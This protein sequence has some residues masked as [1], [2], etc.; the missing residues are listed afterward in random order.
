MFP[1]RLLPAV[2]A[3]MITLTGCAVP[4][5]QAVPAVERPQSIRVASYNIA[6]NDDAAGGVIAR[7]EAGDDRARR[8]AAVI[9]KVRPDIVL[10]NEID[11]DAALRAADLF[12]REYLEVGQFGNEPIRFPYRFA[13]PVNTGEPSGLD[14]DG[15]GTSDG[16]NDA[17]GF[18]RHPGQ[19]AM[20]LLS[21]F[22]IEAERA[23]T[24]R[25]LRWSVMPG[26][27][28][29]INPDGSPFYPDPVW[30]VLRLSSKSHWD[31]PVRTPFGELH[32]LASHPTPPGFDG[33]EDR[34]GARN[35][36]EIRLFADYIAGGSRAAWIVDDA[37]VAGGL[38]DGARFVI[39][40]DQNADPNDGS[41][42]KQAIKQLLEHERV[43]ADVLPRGS[44]GG[45]EYAASSGGAN[46]EH[47]G[48]PD[49]DTGAFSPRVG[50][51]RVDYAL[52]SRN[53]EVIGSAVYWPRADQPGHDWAAASDHRLVWV[54]IHW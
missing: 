37:G 16:P 9:Q 19:Y 13:T 52:P 53:V 33:P 15:D 4:G 40:G 28:R 21:R 32:V 27:E 11:F 1:M 48:D 46:L 26:A 51:M 17:W 3:L 43:H 41:S 2:V 20:L 12:Q 39:L 30:D 18:G 54:D 50:A 8:V 36:D 23:R 25:M 5:P 7:L 42:R 34:N 38:A 10:I 22:P 31:V 14:L 49:F 44:G 6:L 35:H 24:F 47:V 29:P 45:A